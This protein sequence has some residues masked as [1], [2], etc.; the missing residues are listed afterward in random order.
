MARYSYNLYRALEKEGVSVRT[1]STKP[2]DDSALKSGV[3][4]FIRI[5]LT[6]LLR[7]PE[8]SLYHFT[9]PQAG[10]AI[11][12]LR[13]LRKRKIV[14]T[15]YDIN[16]LLLAKERRSYLLV[17]KAL[18][19]AFRNSDALVAISSLAKN[20]IVERFSIDPSL[21]TVT[22]L[23]VDER[24]RPA[25]P[26]TEKP[27]RPFTIGYA[28]GFAANKNVRSLILAFSAFR[29]SYP[30]GSR[31][32]LYGKGPELDNC[33]KLCKSLALG[34]SV[35]FMGFA[36]ESKLPEIHRSFDLFVFPSLTE[37]FGLPIIEAQ[38]SGVP[39][40][41]LSTGRIPEEVTR[42]CL[43]ADGTDGLAEIMND[44]R[45][46]GFVFTPEHRDHLSRFSWRNCALS[47]IKAYKAALGE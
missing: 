27:E 13:S 8:T 37:G 26:G 16:P 33:M 24:F 12:L 25:P 35:S 40:A 34:D 5:P 10:F 44:V 6:A 42:F 9:V 23:G 47:T 29:K 21:I 30:G 19:T 31:L 15:I 17:S 18:E 41:V 28:G 32:L 1:I 4:F 7:K 2:Q 3:D 38:K 46:K 36:D 20:D 11:P 14:S 43:K 39:C 22:S 45:E